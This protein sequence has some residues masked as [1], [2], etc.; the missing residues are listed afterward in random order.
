MKK[1]FLALLAVC[2]LF[3]GCA[4]GNEIS[5]KKD[6][7]DTNVESNTNEETDENKAP[8]ITI[9]SYDGTEKKL[10]EYYGKPIVLN[11]WATWCGFCVE[12]M[13]AFQMLEDK[14]GDDIE[15]M[16]LNCGDTAEEAEAFMA[17]TDFTFD[18]ALV[19][20]EDSFLYG[21]SS[22]PL[23]VIIDQEGNIQFYKMGG[24]EANAFFEKE[25]VPAIDKLLEE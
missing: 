25:L 12:E 2:L 8:D 3:T 4:K 14:Y 22:I 13:P 6:K 20:I 23:T 1:R 10:S 16:L 21:A 19:S 7:E 24:S 9:T 17:E 15:V 5:D 11:F 18:H